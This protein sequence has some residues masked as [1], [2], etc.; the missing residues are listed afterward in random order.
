MTS[1]A[2]ERKQRADD[3][4]TAFALQLSLKRKG[5]KDGQKAERKAAQTPIEVSQQLYY[6][7]M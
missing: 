4:V 7:I 6:E 3:D 1:L 5:S 2:S